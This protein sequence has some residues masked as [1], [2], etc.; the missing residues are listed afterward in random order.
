MFSLIPRKI[1]KQDEH[2]H[3]LEIK[4]L[5]TKFQDFI[6][7]NLPNGL[8]HVR[9]ISH[10]MDLIHRTSFPNKAPHRLTPAENKELTSQV[11]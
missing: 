8:P 10:C 7:N 5:L 6:S 11:Q 2:E 3:A 1:K 9:S 4:S